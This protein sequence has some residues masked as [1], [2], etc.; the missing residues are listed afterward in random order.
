MNEALW[1]LL[2]VLDVEAVGLRGLIQRF[3]ANQLRE[4]VTCLGGEVPRACMSA[5][6]TKTRLAQEVIDRCHAR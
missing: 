2:A 6:A 3:T 1:A 5:H 4:I